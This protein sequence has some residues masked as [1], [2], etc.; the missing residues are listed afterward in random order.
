M[1][2]SL[3]GADISSRALAA[4]G[5]RLFF[6]TGGD[7]LEST[8]IGSGARP[9]T[10]VAGTGCDT[11]SQIVATGSLLG[12]VETAP[13][14]FAHTP[15]V[16]VDSVDCGMRS[17]VTWT[18]WLSDLSG[19]HA[20]KVASGVRPVDSTDT[21]MSPVRLAL[22]TSTYAF[23][24][25][26]SP[27]L[28]ATGETIEVRSVVDDRL[29]WTVQS[30]ARVQDLILGGTSLA[31]LEVEP[32]LELSVADAVNPVLTQI[33]FPASSAS[34]SEDG[35]YLAWDVAADAAH[36]GSSQV[37]TFQLHT[38]ATSS[39]VV[40]SNAPSPTPLRPVVSSALGGPLVAW[41]DTATS[42][43]V[44]PGFLDPWIKANS[45]FSSAEAPEWIALRGSTL[46]LVA[47]DHDARHTVAFALDLSRSGFAPQ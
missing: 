7:T 19:G 22:T 34:L 14:G 18:I 30:G 12:Y 24:R 39:V 9:E 13:H 33:A 2:T 41:Y 29:L 43:I 5:T 26:N 23:N 47:T 17:S 16:P 31:V 38:G 42:G 36:G 21:R 37:V 8:V 27:G 4:V 32:A 28:M 35:Q 44:Y 3:L 11:I 15:G 20:R 40:S 6:V 46:I 45:F 1:R 25:P 10:I